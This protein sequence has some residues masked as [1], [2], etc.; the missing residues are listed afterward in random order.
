[1]SILAI[2][3]NNFCQRVAYIEKNTT[4]LAGVCAG[5]IAALSAAGHLWIEQVRSCP[6]TEA[7]VQQGARIVVAYIEARPERM[8]ED[9]RK[10]AL[11]ALREAWP[12]R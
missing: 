2:A 9:W 10:L 4:Y 11:E 1:M 5:A 12:C 8:H 3:L 6:S 7:T